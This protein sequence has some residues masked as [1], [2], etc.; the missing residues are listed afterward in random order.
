[1]TTFDCGTLHSPNRQADRVVLSNV[2]AESFERSFSLDDFEAS[3]IENAA[4]CCCPKLGQYYNMSQTEW[5]LSCRPCSKE[6][7]LRSCACLFVPR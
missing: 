5:L 4:A 7:L 2:M 3:A 1:M 6:H